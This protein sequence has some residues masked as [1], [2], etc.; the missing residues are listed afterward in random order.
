MKANFFNTVICRGLKSCYD[1]RSS[2]KWREMISEHYDGMDDINFD[3]PHGY[4][5][6]DYPNGCEMV[7]QMPKCKHI[8]E[9]LSSPSPPP[10]KED[11]PNKDSCDETDDATT[12]PPKEGCTGSCDDIPIDVYH[13][14]IKTEIAYMKC[15]GCDSF[16]PVPQK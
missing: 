12:Q 10:P 11:C 7:N 14:D 8:G 4:T 3:C 2:I 1:C 15:F 16:S 5:Q 6:D 9:K 13:C